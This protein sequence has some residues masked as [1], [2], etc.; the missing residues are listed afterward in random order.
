[1][2]WQTGAVQLANEPLAYLG[3]VPTLP[4]AANAAITVGA[5]F[6]LERF[7][8]DGG[9]QNGIPAIFPNGPGADKLCAFWTCLGFVSKSNF[10]LKPCPPQTPA[11]TSTRWAWRTTPPRSRS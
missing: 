4:L 3:S 6:F 10:Q 8:A 2:W 5:F 7:R 11:A 9:E 1:M